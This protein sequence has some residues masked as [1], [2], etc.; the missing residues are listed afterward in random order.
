MSLNY[1]RIA[2]YAKAIQYSKEAIELFEELDIPIYKFNTKMNLGSYQSIIGYFDEAEKNLCEALDFMLQVQDL[3]SAGMCWRYLGQI[4]LHNQDW[5]KAQNS[6]IKAL[7]Y[8]QKAEHRP[9]FEATTLFLGLAYYYD[10][11]YDNAE[12]FII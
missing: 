8:H 10:Q 6:F 7:G 2:D 12:K 4:E 9:A 11:Q 1:R 3:K 5:K